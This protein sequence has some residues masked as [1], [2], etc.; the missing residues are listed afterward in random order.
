MCADFGNRFGDFT[1]FGFT[2]EPDALLR[3]ELSARLGIVPRTIDFGEAGHFFFY[4]SYGDVAETNEAIVLTL[5][6]IHTSQGSPLSSQALLDRGLVSPSQVKA[7]EL[8]GNGLI[9]CFSKSSP[10]LSVYKTLLS[11]PQL[12]YSTH[13]QA[14]LCTDGPKP[15]L[16]LLDRVEVNEEAIV[17][18]FLFRYALGTHS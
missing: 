3:H 1:V 8:R 2:E 14:L 18:H 15:H 17:Q 13:S 11:M 4:T 5:G 6:L 10:E 12:Y 7:D 16:A 9:A